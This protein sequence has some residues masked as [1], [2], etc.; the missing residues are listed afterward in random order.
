MDTSQSPINRD[1]VR[2]LM[3]MH[4]FIK[5]A[6]N[7]S[8]RISDED[9]PTQI[10]KYGDKSRNHVL[11]EMAIELRQMVK[12]IQNGSSAEP[13]AGNDKILRVYRGRPVYE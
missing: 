3:V 9:A 12:P 2:L 1:Y 10:L 11:R 4:R 7:L 5:E 13:G 8:I 6:F